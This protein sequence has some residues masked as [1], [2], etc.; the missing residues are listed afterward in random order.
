MADDRSPLEHA[1]GDGEDFELVFA[2][3]PAD[4]TALLRAPP[5]PGLTVIGE[6]IAE[7]GLWLEENG[8]R[9]PLPPLGYV[10][11]LS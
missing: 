1:L 8:Q 6:C 9:R 7:A 5:I 10:H 11:G 4:A 3:A 2:V